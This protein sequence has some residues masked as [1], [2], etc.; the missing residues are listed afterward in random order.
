MFAQLGSVLFDGLLSPETFEQQDSE[1]YAEHARI[2]NK[3]RLQRTGSGLREIQFAMHLNAAFCTP[4]TEAQKLYDAMVNA[5]VLPLVLGTGQVIGDFVILTIKKTIVQ[6]FTDGASLELRLDV[7]IKEYFIEDR[8]VVAQ[9]T[10]QQNAF[11]RNDR[12]TVAVVP[13]YQGNPA[14]NLTAQVG[15][16]ERDFSY[17]ESSLDNYDTGLTDELLLESATIDKGNAIKNAMDKI[18]DIW[19]TSSTIQAKA[20]DLL[21]YVQDVRDAVTTLQSLMPLTDV[22]AFRQ[23]MLVTKSGLA[24]VR[25]GSTTIAGLAAGRVFAVN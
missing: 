5:E 12:Q 1:N 22:A 3:P 4:D 14:Q 10:A 16:S 8:K 18:E 15:Q 7:S 24:S 9:Q 21:V 20:A 23:Q 17:I 11:A 19:N 13:A 25:S 2:E 6:A